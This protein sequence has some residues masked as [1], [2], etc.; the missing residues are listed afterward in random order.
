MVSTYGSL[1]T[2]FSETNHDVS[3]QVEPNDIDAAR[4]TDA[5]HWIESIALGLALV[6]LVCIFGLIIYGIIG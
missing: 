2:K 5:D 3:V 4:L 6:L 1:A